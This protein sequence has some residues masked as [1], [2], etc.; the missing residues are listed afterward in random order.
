MTISWVRLAEAQ[1]SRFAGLSEQERFA[2]FLAVQCGR[3]IGDNGDRCGDGAAGVGL[4]LCAATGIRV[5]A[6]AD[7]LMREV[8]T[9]KNPGSDEIQ[10]AFFVTR[11]DRTENNRVARKGSATHVAGVVGRGVAL[12]FEYPR[13]VFRTLEELWSLCS[14]WDYDLRIRGLDRAALVRGAQE[15]A[16]L[17]EMEGSFVEYFEEV[18]E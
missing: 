17:Y 2:Y 13:A 8:F 3:S 16:G 9:G 4:A 18:A 5:R 14:L 10:A 1:R 7:R 11:K 15:G 12:S 6:D